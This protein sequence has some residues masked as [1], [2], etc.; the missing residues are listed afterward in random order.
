M[1]KRNR[2]F[3]RIQEQL[4]NSGY[5]KNDSV[6]I[7]YKSVTDTRRI[8]EILS[9]SNDNHGELVFKRP[10][11]QNNAVAPIPILQNACSENEPSCTGESNNPF[12]KINGQCNN[13]GGKLF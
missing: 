7:A 4:E 2:I 5:S 13:L 12:R 8:D 1:Y 9:H 11:G 10:G 3:Q 6:Q